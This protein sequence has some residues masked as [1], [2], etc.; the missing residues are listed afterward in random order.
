MKPLLGSQIQKHKEHISGLD[1]KERTEIY[2]E[3]VKDF[4]QQNLNDGK[5]RWI[6]SPFIL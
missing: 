5:G 4:Y 3:F 1:Q 2:D 6:E